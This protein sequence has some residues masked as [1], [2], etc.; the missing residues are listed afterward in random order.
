[1]EKGKKRDGC[2]EESQIDG[3]NEGPLFSQRMSRHKRTFCPLAAAEAI[4]LSHNDTVITERQPKEDSHCPLSLHSGKIS[5]QGQLYNS[6]TTMSEFLCLY[7]QSPLD[8]QRVFL[9]ITG[10]FSL[11]PCR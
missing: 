1:M 9:K 7:I 5:K 2:G 10:I 3:D 6:C 4:L 11:M 8:L